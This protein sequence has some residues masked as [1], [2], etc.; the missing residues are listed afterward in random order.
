MALKTKTPEIESY[1]VACAI[2]ALKRR[3]TH[4]QNE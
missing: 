4:D 3:V 1:F 2:R